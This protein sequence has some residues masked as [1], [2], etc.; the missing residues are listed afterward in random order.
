[1]QVDIRA[2]APT[3]LTI[4]ASRAVPGRLRPR[5]AAMSRPAWLYWRITFADQNFA[6]VVCA[7]GRPVLSGAP[8]AL[9]LLDASAPSSL[10][11]GW[12]GGGQ[13]R[14]Q[15]VQDE[16]AHGGHPR[17]LRGGE[18]RRQPPDARPGGQRRER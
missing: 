5:A 9:V 16:R 10:V 15:A 4:A 12:R 2:S 6:V 11:R 18:R 7:A 8:V 13:E 1:C 14:V 3:R 17:G